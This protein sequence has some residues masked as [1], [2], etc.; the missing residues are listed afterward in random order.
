MIILS[1]LKFVKRKIS[2]VGE[3]P[4]WLCINNVQNQNQGKV[5]P[6]SVDI[7]VKMDHKNLPGGI[8]TSQDDSLTSFDINLAYDHKNAVGGVLTLLQEGQ[9]PFGSKKSIRSD[10]IDSS[11]SN[12]IC[13]G[14]IGSDPDFRSGNPTLLDTSEITP[15]GK[16]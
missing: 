10:R 1:N 6:A 4:Y 7:N 5:F 14:Q 2:E 13:P 15:R 8:L 11:R 3:K 16:G 12:R 9:G